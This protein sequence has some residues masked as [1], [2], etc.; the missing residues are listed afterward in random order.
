[1]TILRTSLKTM[2]SA[3]A[4]MLVSLLMVT[5]ASAEQRPITPEDIWAVDRPSAPVMSPDGTRAIIGLTSFSM[6][7][8]RGTTS[9]Y[10]LNLDDNS[11]TPLTRPR[12]GSDSSPVWSPDGKTVAFVSRRGANSNQIFLMRTDGGE[13]IQLTD[14][15][16]GVSA[17][18][19]MPDGE[20]LVFMA[21]VPSDFNGDFEALKKQQ[22]EDNKSKVSAFVTENRLYR[23]WDRFLPQDTYPRLFK[24]NTDSKEVSELTPGWARF[25]NIGGGVS[26]DIS[27]DGSLI[28]LTANT[29]EAPY[30]SLKA[31]VL[32]LK[33]DGSGDYTNIT[34]ENTG[35][36][37]NPIFSNNGEYVLYGRSIRT[38]FYADQLNLVRYNVRTSNERVLTENFDNT[39]S[40]WQYSRDGNRIFFE[41]GDRAM[42]SI[43][44]IPASGGDVRE[45]LRGGTNNG[46]AETADGRLV[47]VH[48]ALSFMP[49]LFAVSSDGGNKSQLS[50]FNTALQEQIAWGRV[51]NVTYVG[52]N[53]AP[54]Q[55]FVIYPPDFDESQTYPVLNLLHGG[56]HGFFGDTFHYRWN[57]QVFS[58]PG[59]ITIMPNFHGSTSF[60]QDFAISIHGEH[61]T[62]PYID[63]EKAIEYMLEKPYVDGDRLAAAGGSYGGYLVS[64]IAGQ[65]DRYAALINH[66]GVYNLMGQFASD[67]TAHRA[68]AYGG[69]PWD[70]LDH[71]LQW[72]PAMNAANFKTPM[73]VIH[74]ELDYR[75]PVTQGFEVY[76]VY[77]G[78]GLDARL[79]YFPDENH[80][81]LKPNNS[82]FWFSEFHGWLDRYLGAGAQ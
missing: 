63:S 29:T 32:L 59:Y 68:Y 50:N 25:F 6:E 57:A 41:A 38:D 10:M 28:A 82:V 4:V 5:V 69:A 72:S 58:A 23:H 31:D 13:P 66:A 2:V 45:I 35:R 27:P 60:G 19:W 20:H 67:T 21:Q 43:F 49:E 14:L 36:S 1:M 12:S 34:T 73:L 70:G 40:N 47:F 37:V 52:A 75:V 78:M 61:P 65:T 17:P 39:P 80:W 33:T 42:T 16:I 9:L 62:L 77:K 74:G 56:P 54:V 55:M 30:D 48:H 11:I 3:T 71:M 8:D 15:P 81:I 44:S 24:V 53:G 46:A 64:W 18:K 26:Y 7:T 79:V 22:E 51:E 76:G